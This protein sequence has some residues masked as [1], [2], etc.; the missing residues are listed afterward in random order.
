MGS[1]V[2]PA[3]KMKNSKEISMC[4][5][6]TYSFINVFGFVQFAYRYVCI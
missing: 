2:F 3:D 1:D 6:Q 4:F 5:W